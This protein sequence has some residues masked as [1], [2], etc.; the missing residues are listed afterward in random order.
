MFDIAGP[1]GQAGIACFFRWLQE[2][3]YFSAGSDVEA[4]HK[5]ERDALR[6]VVPP[7]RR[8]LLI[9]AK[10]GQGGSNEEPP[11]RPPDS[12]RGGVLR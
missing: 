5:E 4:L 6:V 8:R 2:T 12:V 10:A 1:Q 3:N 7:S 9:V 11:A